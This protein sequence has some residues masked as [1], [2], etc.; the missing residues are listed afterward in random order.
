MYYYL[1]VQ[2]VG[3]QQ[4]RVSQHFFAVLRKEARE[5]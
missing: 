5:S 3:L 2:E 4:Q 1:V